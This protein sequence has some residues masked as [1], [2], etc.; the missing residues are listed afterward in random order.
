MDIQCIAIDPETR[1]VSI[2]LGPRIVTGSTKLLQIVVLS[3]LNVPGKDVLDPGQGGGLPSL[4]GT[5]ID[6]SD[7][8]EIFS[9]VV[10]RV[11]K[12]QREII[13]N[14]IGLNL[15]AAERL[16]ELQIVNIQSGDSADAVDVQIRVLDASGRAQD[17]VL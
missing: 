9:E 8:T 6:P 2:K 13:Q 14:Q 11:K 1:R 4:I 3:L 7:E 15:P 5:N 10:R 16:V 17:V 12:S